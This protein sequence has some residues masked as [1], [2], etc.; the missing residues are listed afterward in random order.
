MK[1][2]DL[3]L[4]LIKNLESIVC[5]LQQQGGTCYAVGGSVRDLV[6]ELE[7]KD[8]DIEVHGISSETLEAT[9]KNFGVVQLLGK[10]FGVFRIQKYDID[11]SL[12]RRDSAG[13]KP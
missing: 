9:L 3:F 1:N 11:W 6:L 4:A 5:A 8:L 13:R 12:P 10:K 2:S 7:I